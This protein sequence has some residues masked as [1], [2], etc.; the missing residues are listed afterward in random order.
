MPI[1]SIHD[2]NDDED[3]YH[4]DGDDLCDKDDGEVRKQ[5]I[6]GFQALLRPGR[7]WLGS[8]ARQLSFYR[9]QC[10]FTIHSATNA[11]IVI[12]E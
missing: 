7:R 4:D 10:G 12:L 2:K 3:D 9:S 11:A 8:Y 6:S 5:V 1:L